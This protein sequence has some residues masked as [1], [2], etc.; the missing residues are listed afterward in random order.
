MDSIYLQMH[1]KLKQNLERFRPFLQPFSK[2]A[3]LE[4]FTDL[5]LHF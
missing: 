3:S 2:V 4:M 1:S 5:F